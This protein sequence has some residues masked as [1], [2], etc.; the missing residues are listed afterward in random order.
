M[1]GTHL[2]LGAE[3]SL[4]FQP[5]ARI[6]NAGER[7]FA[8][9]WILGVLA[10][11]GVATNPESK[12]AAWTALGSLASAPVHERTLTGL[13]VLLQS[14]RLRQA[15][16]PYTLEGPYG[17]LLD[18]DDDHLALTDVQCFEMEDLMHTPA[19]VAPV[20]TYLF[21]RLETK[22]NGRP[23]LLVLDE[24][25]VFLD[26]PLFAGRIREWL[27]TLRKKNVSVVFAT[28]S[29]ADITTSSIAPALIESCP[30][31]IFLANERA[32]EPQQHETYTRFGLNERQIDIIGSASPKRDYYLQ[33]PRGSRLFELALG[34]VALALCGA[35]SAEDQRLIGEV[36]R[37]TGLAQFARVFLQ[38]KDLPW[39]ADLMAG[40]SPVSGIRARDAEFA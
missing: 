14:T 40:W 16:E 10:K 12:E 33:S 3:D 18:A 38:E 8:L 28:Q 19:I 24:A 29:L 6:D 23:T 1:G 15:L 4:A 39:A 13:S 31:R 27:K 2:D 25:W 22:F 34:P 11:E 17:R 36:I 37:K 26:D 5:L 7:A 32:R 9:D 21:H 20:L 35:G 30:T